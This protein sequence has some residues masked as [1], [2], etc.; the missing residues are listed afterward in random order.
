MTLPNNVRKIKG[1]N[2][3]SASKFLVREPC[4]MTFRV[5]C[6]L[7]MALD[8]FFLDCPEEVLVLLAIVNGSHIF[9]HFQ[10][11]VDESKSQFPECWCR[12]WDRDRC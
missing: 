8:Y 10:V 5:Y 11:G 1:L 7:H 3:S 2:I 6:F 4:S 12:V 9:L